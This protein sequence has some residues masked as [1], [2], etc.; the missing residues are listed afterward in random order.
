MKNVLVSIAASSTLLLAGYAMADVEASG[1]YLNAKTYANGNPH[2][3]PIT[4]GGGTTLYFYANTQNERAIFFNAE[5]AVKS[6]DNFTWENIDIEVTSPSGVTRV[7]PASSSDNAFCTSEGNNVLGNWESNETHG[8]YYTSEIGYHRV[9]VKGQLMGFTAGE[10]VR[11]D[12]IS[13]IV[14]D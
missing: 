8:V 11:M 12:D 6:A 7:V 9:R 1:Y 3:L 2:Y 4:S 13:L 5:C 10:Q 14:M